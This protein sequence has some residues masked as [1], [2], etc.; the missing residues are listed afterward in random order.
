LQKWVEKQLSSYPVSE[1]WADVPRAK[2]QHFQ[3]FFPLL[4]FLHEFNYDTQILD[5]DRFPQG[6]GTG[7]KIEG[8]V[9]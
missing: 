3:N 9:L 1:M 5:K 2:V 4:D 8:G 7:W 6:F